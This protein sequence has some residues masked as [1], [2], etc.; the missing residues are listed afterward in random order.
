M[1]LQ[2][3]FKSQILVSKRI[4]KMKHTCSISNI[5]IYIYIEHMYEY[6]GNYYPTYGYDRS[7]SYVDD[8]YFADGRILLQS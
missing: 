3:F 6:L 8:A 7:D 2:V 5:Y 4:K 1:I